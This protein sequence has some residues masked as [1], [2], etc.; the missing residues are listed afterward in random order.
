MAVRFCLLEHEGN[1]LIGEQW[2]RRSLQ[3]VECADFAKLAFAQWLIWYN[4]PAEALGI[5][6]ETLSDRALD[7]QR[8]YYAALAARMQRHIPKLKRLCLDCIE[9]RLPLSRSAI[10]LHSY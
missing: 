3:D 8:D 9:V 7:E 10:S 5:L 4:R 2:Y 1:L 6:P